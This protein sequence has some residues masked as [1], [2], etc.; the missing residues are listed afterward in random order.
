MCLLLRTVEGFMAASSCCGLR[1]G[2]CLCAR[3]MNR[4]CSG[5]GL[6][7]HS[8]TPTLG[9]CPPGRGWHGGK[10]QTQTLEDPALSARSCGLMLVG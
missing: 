10:N 1:E 3:G 7:I 9:W 4:G 5:E 2:V 8:A 6:H